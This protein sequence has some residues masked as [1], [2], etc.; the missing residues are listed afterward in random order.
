MRGVNRFGVQ[1]AHAIG[2]EHGIAQALA[3]LVAL[4]LQQDP[5]LLTFELRQMTTTLVEVMPR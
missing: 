4:V 5:R 3:H 2:G 1:R